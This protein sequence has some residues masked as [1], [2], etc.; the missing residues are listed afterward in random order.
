MS[1]QKPQTNEVR[2]P[3]VLVAPF[4]LAEQPMFAVE[5]VDSEHHVVSKNG[6]EML[7]LLQFCMFYGNKTGTS[8]SLNVTVGDNIN[9]PIVF[10]N[11]EIMSCTYH[12]VR[13][14]MYLVLRHD[15]NEKPV[16]LTLTPYGD[17][18]P[19]ANLVITQVSTA[20]DV[21]PR[22]LYHAFRNKKLRAE[23]SQFGFLATKKL[24][25]ETG[26]IPT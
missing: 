7:N 26:N 16:T 21:F 25:L 11:P 6:P 18:G 12:P 10:Q 8:H 24:T 23:E 3:L 15:S 19:H 2:I 1:E 5:V 22:D 20:M 14:M 9:P 17:V 13:E 4:R